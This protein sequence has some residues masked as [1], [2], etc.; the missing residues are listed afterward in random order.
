MKRVRSA[1]RVLLVWLLIAAGPAW[2]LAV[3]AQQPRP[4]PTKPAQDEFVPIDQ[5]PPGEQLPA[6]P[7]LIAAYSVAWLAVAGV[8]RAEGP[9]PL[10]PGITPLLLDIEVDV[11]MDDRIVIKQARPYVF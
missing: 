7:L 2:S 9:G 3:G 8:A 10:Y 6:A 5:L 4:Q 1:W 11:T